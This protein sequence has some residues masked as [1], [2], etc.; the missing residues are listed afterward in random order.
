[1]KKIIVVGGGAAG[2][3]AAINLAEKNPH[4]DIT[5]L[6]RSSSVLNKVKISGGGR[7]NV[8]HA[9]FEPKE[10]IKN[11]PRGEKQLLGP[12]TRFNP[13]HTIDWFFE[14]GVEIKQED[15]GR[16]FPISD[17]SQTIIDCFIQAA[18]NSG[19]KIKMQTGVELLQPVGDKIQITT[20][21]KEILVADAVILTTGSST[22]IWKMLEG[23]GHSIVPPVPS[24]F[25]FNITDARLEGLQGLAVESAWVRI[26]SNSISQPA[27]VG[28][29]LITH[30]GLSGPAILK[31]SAFC[32]REL[33]EANHQFKIEIN[34]AN[35]RFDKVK[36]TLIHFKNNH[37]K[38]SVYGNPLFGIPKRLW[39]RILM[40]TIQPKAEKLKSSKH[41]IPHKAI[42]HELKY[43]DLSHTFID[44][45]AKELTGAVFQVRG[46]STFKD[47]FVTAGGIELNEVD[48]KTMQ[49]KKIR[50]LYF[51][52]EVLDI[53]AVTGGFN[54]QAAWTTG[55][56]AAQSI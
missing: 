4:Y 1:M 46:K 8:T 2:F 5:I 18:K 17:S 13:T 19:V 20:N 6:E 47:E 43:A 54:F 3:F 21:T 44:S 10:L 11:Y 37:S 49:S 15:D 25:T 30:W 45:I 51:A 40:Q 29:L 36:E 14:R 48:F 38:K 27:I 24:L 41:N 35:S 28:P 50:G 12:F 23:I 9:C 42:T 16:I 56:L 22:T 52:G 33:A 31:L 34:W 7:C 39:E 26:P 53:D 55:W 32:A